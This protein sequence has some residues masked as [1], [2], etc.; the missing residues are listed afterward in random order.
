VQ[1]DLSSIKKSWMIEIWEK[2][3]SNDQQ[4]RRIRGGNLK[5]T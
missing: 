1:T 3:E 2:E 4:R 5:K